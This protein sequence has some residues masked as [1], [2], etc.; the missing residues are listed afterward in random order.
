MIYHAKPS[1]RRAPMPKPTTESIINAAKGTQGIDL[2]EFDEI[3][4]VPCASTDGH[5][6]AVRTFCKNGEPVAV[7][8]INETLNMLVLPII[9]DP[10]RLKDWKSA[11]DISRA[12]SERSIRY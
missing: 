4:I 5:E 6:I 8:R 10:K 7:E 12:F 3:V 1:K 11:T 9:T 2:I